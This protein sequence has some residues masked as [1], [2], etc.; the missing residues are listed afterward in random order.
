MNNE[1]ISKIDAVETPLKNEPL[2][3]GVVVRGIPEHI[4]GLLDF[5]EHSDLKTIYK[6]ASY[7]KMYITDTKEE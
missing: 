5:L 1:N 2:T 4:Q 7:G 3:Y 6:H